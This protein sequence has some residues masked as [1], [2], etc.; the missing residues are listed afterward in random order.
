[1]GSIVGK[2]QGLG[3]G[4]FI[5]ENIKTVLDLI[6]HLVEILRGFGLGEGFIR[7]ITIFYRENIGRLKI[8]NTLGKPFRICRGVRQGDPMSAPEPAK[9]LDP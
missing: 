5:H 6:Y 8:N 3:K 9:S 2:E 1:M 7:W 4:R